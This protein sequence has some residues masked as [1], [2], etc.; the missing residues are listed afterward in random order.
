MTSPARI[1]TETLRPATPHGAAPYV[2][3]PIPRQETPDRPEIDLK[4]LERLRRLAWWLDS[5]WRIPGTRIP[6]GLD[7][8]A[9]VVPGIGSTATA[10]VSA[11]IVYEATRFDVPK[12]LLLRMAGNLG[13]D[14]LLGAIPVI[15]PVFDVGFKANR[16]NLDLL[17]RHL[18]ERLAG[19][20]MG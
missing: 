14:W 9:S 1:R 12:S 13:L 7:G 18:E 5:R 8:I 2:A 20:R 6:I 3:R 16:K 15:G 11:Y 4:L 10:L 19:G 17:H